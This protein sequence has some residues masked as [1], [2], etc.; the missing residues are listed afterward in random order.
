MGCCISICPNKEILAQYR[1]VSGLHR[2]H[3]MQNTATALEAVKALANYYEA[4]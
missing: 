3:L 4:K 2:K 1:E